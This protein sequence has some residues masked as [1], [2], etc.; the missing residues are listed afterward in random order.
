MM[1][2]PENDKISPLRDQL[3]L[4]QVQ[5]EP[6]KLHVTQEKGHLDILNGKDLPM[7]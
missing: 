1:L 6:K 4:F 3:D 5:S 2:V 7:L